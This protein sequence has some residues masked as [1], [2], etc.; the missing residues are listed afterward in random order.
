MAELSEDHGVA[1]GSLNI[2]FGLMDGSWL[3]WRLSGAL[4]W[5]GETTGL[6]AR[7]VICRNT[8][9]PRL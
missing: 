9:P 4:R 3:N 2:M 1:I 5:K 7:G 8:A 6:E